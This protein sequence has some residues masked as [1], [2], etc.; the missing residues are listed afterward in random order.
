M[1]RK[2]ISTGLLN[3]IIISL[4]LLPG[5]GRA[6]DHLEITVMTPDIVDGRPAATVQMGI[7]VLV[8]A[9]NLDGS[10]DTAADYI[11]AGL[12]SP[13]V[14]ATLPSS[15]YLVAGERIFNGVIFLDDGL[16]V[17]LRV[18]DLDDGSV[19]FAEVEINCFNHV[20]NFLLNITPG[21]KYVGIQTTVT[22]T[23]RD[24]VGAVVRNF[25]EDVILVPTIGEFTAGPSITVAGGD[26]SLG[27]ATADITF[28]GTD[29]MTHQN[30]LTATSTIV[31]TGQ[32]GAAVGTLVVSPVYPSALN[33]IILVMPGETLTPGVSPGKSGS[34]TPQISGFSFGG[35]D[36][37]ATDQYWNP[38]AAA[39]YPTLTWSTD[40]TSP[41]VV[42]P[43]SVA[44]VD[45]AELDNTVALVASGQ[46]QLTVQASGAITGSSTALVFINPAGLDHFRFNYAFFD[47]NTVQAT[48]N[49]FPVTVIAEDAF[50]NAFPY[51]GP[52][53]MR[54]I[55]GSTDESPDYL[56]SST[57]VF[58]NGQL[59]AMM[60]VTKRAFEVRLIIDSNT[61]VLTYSGVF[62]V[63]AGP[64]DRILFTM[65]GETWVPGLN[66][67][68]FSG[69]MGTPTT[70]TSGG[71]C[72]PI[73]VRAVDRYANLVS[74][75]RIINLTCPT[76]YMMLFDEYLNL[77][78]SNMVTINGPTEFKASFRTAGLQQLQ[79]VVG[80][81][82]T[83]LST[84]VLVNPFIYYQ[85][86]L[87]A[88]GEA[89]D[90]G[91]FE[92]DGKIGDPT[93]A[94]AGSSFSLEVYAVDYFFNPVDNA[95]PKLPISL[96]FT[97]SDAS[98]TMPAGT[99]SMLLNSGN[100][101]ATLV[102]LENPNQQVV[103]VS[104][105]NNGLND[106]VVIPIVA[107]PLDHFDIGINSNSTPTP[108]DL[109][110]PVP[111]HQ[112]GSNLPDLTVV[113]RD[114]FNNY[115]AGYVDSVSLSLSSGGTVLTPTRISL[116]DGFGTGSFD[117][118]W[119]GMS[120]ITY[121]GTDLML[122]ATDDVFGR[123]GNSN[124]FTVFPGAY[125]KLQIVLP[126]ENATPGMVPGKQGV[127]L[128]VA[129]GD[130][131][132]ASVTALDVWWNP[133]S[134]Q[135]FV[136]LQ[137]S[138]YYQLLSANDI[139]LS[140]PGTANF[141]VVLRTAATQIL[142]VA[143]LSQSSRC[144]TST[145][146]VQA[147]PYEKLQLV[148]PGETVDPGGFEFDGKTGTPGDQVKSVNF[149]VQILAVDRLWN[150]IAS[151]NN[152]AHL[153]S[154]EGS[155]VAGNPIQ[156]DQTMSGGQ[157][158]MDL[159]LNN[160]GLA[161][162]T[163]SDLD[164]PLMTA[165]SVPLQILN[166]G[167]YR[168][169][170]PDTAFVGPPS[171]F[172]VTVELIDPMGNPYVDA[173]NTIQLRALLPSHGPV[174]GTLMVTNAQLSSGI[175]T[176]ATQAYDQVQRIIIEVTDAAGRVNYSDP[177][178]MV[179][180]AL[181]Y[182]ITLPPD[183]TMVVGPPA[184]FPVT[185]RLIETDTGNLV[186]D[187]RFLNVTILDGVGQPGT[188]A[189]GS[190]L[191][192]LIGG[193]VTFNQSYTRSGAFILGVSDSTGLN[194]M[195]SLA[196][197][198]NSGYQRLQL[199]VPGETAQPGISAYVGTGKSG[200]PLLQ[201]CGELFA[202]DVR[203]VDQYWN[204]VDT[205]NSGTIHFASDDGSFAAAANPQ[206]KDVPF[207]AG[208]RST[209][210]YLSAAGSVNISVSDLDHSGLPGQTVAVPTDDA[211]EYV[212]TV[213]AVA[214]TGPLP[215]FAMSVQLV[216]PDTGNVILGANNRIVL[217]VLRADYS[218]AAGS[219][220][221]DETYLAAGIISI[222]DQSYGIYEDIM[223]RVRD[224]FGR[225]TISSLIDMQTTGMY[226]SIVIPDSATVGGPATFPLSIEL[227]DS[228]TGNRVVRNGLVD[229][230]VY[231]SSTGQPGNG[232]QGISQQV[233]TGGYVA[234]AQTYTLAEEIFIRVV[235][236]DSIQ[237]V[238]NSCRM[239]ADGFKQVQLLAPG[240]LANPGSE[241]GTGKTGDTLVQPSGLPFTLEVRAV[242][243][244]WNPVKSVN[245]GAIELDCT[246]GGGLTYVNGADYHATFVSGIRQIGVYFTGAGDIDIFA[247]DPQHP[248]AAAGNTRVTITEAVYEITVPDSAFVGPPS[249]FQIDVRLLNPDTNL[250]VPESTPFTMTALNAARQ[251]ATTVLGVTSGSLLDGEASIIGQYYGVSEDIVVQISDSRGR[252]AFSSVISI[253][254]MGV[255]FAITVPD[256]VLAGEP[257]PVTVNR[258]DIGTGLPVL[259][260]DTNFRIEAVNA[261]SGVARPD[262]TLS[263]A[264]NLSFIHGQTVG[265]TAYLQNQTYDRAETIY[266]RVS[267]DEGGNVLSS[268]V[269]VRPAPASAFTL[270]LERTGD[271]KLDKALRPGE[272]IQAVVVAV[273]RSGNAAANATVVFRVIDGTGILGSGT[274]DVITSRTDLQG[275]AIQTVGVA[276]YCD[277]NVI[278]EVLVDDLEPMQVISAVDGPPTT[279]IDMTGVA[280]VYE[281]GWYISFDT[282]INLAAVA[283]I[284]GESTL[285][286]FDLDGADGLSPTTP[287]DGEFT[288]ADNLEE[289]SGL[290][291]LRY[292]AVEAESGVRSRIVTLN[293]YTTTQLT[294]AKPISNRP[295][296]FRAGSD[297]TIILFNPPRGGT[298]NLTIYDLYGAVVL[299]STVEVLPGQTNQFVWDGR[300]GSGNVVGNGGYICRVVGSGY[301]FRR[302]IAVV[303]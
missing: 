236:G 152:R 211:Y 36:V 268:A 221:I 33:R 149:P 215:G 52:V 48:T 26:F 237:G 78:S 43:A 227:L 91:T 253:V 168:I 186:D 208:Q 125:E 165:Q 226:Y 288:L 295:N 6:F 179:P 197:I 292:Y 220:A 76:G 59:D 185:I 108:H 118:V 67:V 94:D 251:A 145:V 21:D 55:I 173:H 289:V 190:T 281:D 239:I 260:Y 159:F 188:G 132:S 163:A 232:V 54:V 164:D 137:S 139:Q 49:P 258:V 300:N 275:R 189:I 20:D 1:K 88:P 233:L 302:K 162:L 15:R 133:V 97:T 265:G 4:L 5:V 241:A 90:P 296:P 130:T 129:A 174:S 291:V 113:A 95:S 42:L 102:T 58:Q 283:G 303:K 158:N 7:S 44:M 60:Q 293:L 277:Q 120:R 41:S 153:G 131:I 160:S 287:Y 11:H 35:V 224:D 175:I 83:S 126:G 119:R 257:W 250:P 17:R 181:Q 62:Q 77:I 155:V 270:V 66:N 73:M 144:D 206:D 294:S 99:Q 204:L 166:I 74:G 213:P 290:H 218:P 122:T 169:T 252:T 86:I 264:G 238:S 138:H 243:Q 157:I 16:P 180:T 112:A 262:T 82:T 167:E 177:I 141:N 196:N 24:I 195:S 104:D 282:L 279:D 9:V 142:D 109:L 244:F 297:E 105:P 50:N 276:E 116:L 47:T 106:S 75:E 45:N 194:G 84:S 267:D 240:E 107:G 172:T 85:L 23:A 87:V 72:D 229:V 136:H 219:L 198:A 28:Q 228:A 29:P 32:A 13:D 248:F 123:T 51:N 117:G 93:P 242:D 134:D 201:R 170:T 225:S 203:A 212:I 183:S 63:N 148:L 192:R 156:N 12:L 269:T 171:A 46:R 259:G 249:T 3:L 280:M 143:D 111:D 80:G 19:P 68:N 61:G 216:D 70:I 8:R 25:S 217:E 100:F 272:E 18:S 210:A 278:L 40:D 222:P 147:G 154:D 151:V 178:Q 199:I 299:S 286:Y 256:T 209:M 27:V 128:P 71:M 231:S 101:P 254:P 176:L 214:T 273:D 38:V 121:A 30:T 69:N 223:I 65:P 161:T 266:L 22:L 246:D 263:P 200:S 193:A 53:S 79:A 202:I 271:Q 184:V 115:I 255:T 39:P 2:M 114:A 127:P 56:I 187:N 191:Q 261:W 205:L 64:I 150:P 230:V 274:T 110:S 298:A 135:P 285:I 234:I 182:Q 31:Y 57:N 96:N 140:S 34:P 247:D 207:I 146:I 89:L 98:A 235:D 81:V 284:E 245:N 103:T 14:P 10:T 124:V 92:P 37:Y 301:E